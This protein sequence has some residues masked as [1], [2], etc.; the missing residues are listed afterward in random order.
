MVRL[1][2][3]PQLQLAQL[4]AQDRVTAGELDGGH[5]V[6]LAEHHVH[7]HAHL[8]I[9]PQQEVAVRLPQALP[10]VHH[11]QHSKRLAA[12]GEVRAHGPLPT[13][14]L[15]LGGECEAIA[16]QVD[17]LRPEIV[18]VEVDR[19]GDARAVGDGRDT[20]CAAAATS[21]AR[22]G[23]EEAGLAHVG[24]ASE[25]DLGQQRLGQILHATRRAKE[26]H[27]AERALRGGRRRR[28]RS[29][30]RA[31]V[32]AAAGFGGSSEAKLIYQL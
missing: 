26:A 3:V 14:G 15:L 16:R 22:E 12:P 24:A 9:Q 23:V 27:S 25:G 30:R 4:G 1:H 32:S 5:E 28:R 31:S 19:A 18:G 10:R 2:Q 6:A 20:H 11:K 21:L 8:P 13:L 7:R 17:Q 29:G